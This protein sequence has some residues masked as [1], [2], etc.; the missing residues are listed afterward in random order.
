MYKFNFS[1]RYYGSTDD[2][3]YIYVVAVAAAMH[4]IHNGYGI[5]ILALYSDWLMVHWWNGC[6]WI[7]PLPSVWFTGNII[8]GPTVQVSTIQKN[9]H[10]QW[11]TVLLNRP[12]WPKQLILSRENSNCAKDV[13]LA[14]YSSYY[15]CALKLPY[16][17][18][19]CFQI[20]F[21]LSTNW[22]IKLHIILHHSKLAESWGISMWAG[23]SGDR[24]T[25]T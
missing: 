3:G 4:I 24:C 8:N 12:W 21:I 7:H 23:Y 22:Y 6:L 17:R 2:Y 15:D 10:L 19:L 16:K 9:F 14:Y 5:I 18:R 25:N 20:N 13:R 11:M 1:F